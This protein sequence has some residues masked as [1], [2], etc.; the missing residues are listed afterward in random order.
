MVCC[1]LISFVVFGVLVVFVCLC[2]LLLLLLFRSFFG[3]K[4]VA[5]SFAL[6][7]ISSSS[8]SSS[9]CVLAS[10]PRGIFC[11]YCVDVVGGGRRRCFAYRGAPGDGCGC[12]SCRPQGERGS[13]H[14][15]VLHLLWRGLRLRDLLLPAGALSPLRERAPHVALPEP[16]VIP[17]APIGV[18]G[19]CGG[20]GSRASCGGLQGHGVEGE[21]GRGG[22]RAMRSESSGGLPLFSLLQHSPPLG[23]MWELSRDPLFVVVVVVSCCCCCCSR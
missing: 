5:S 10:P 18:C 21:G 23:G 3:P 4:T 15:R 16:P 11:S 6:N 17:H 20:S 9:S 14:G 2:L 22:R 8:S 12:T 7:S 19:N 13:W 1:V